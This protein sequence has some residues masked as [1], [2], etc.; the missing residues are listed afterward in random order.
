M[1]KD[2]AF[3]T[4]IKVLV[5]GILFPIYYMLI[6][7]MVYLLSGSGIYALGYLGF[8]VL[9]VVSFPYLK[10]VILRYKHRSRFKSLMDD[11]LESTLNRFKELRALML[12]GE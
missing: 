8:S 5:A 3:D 2:H 7:L 10:K 4:S 1:I 12:Q 11:S 6:S 9:T